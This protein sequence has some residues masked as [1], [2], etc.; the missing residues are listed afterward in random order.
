MRRNRSS[1]RRTCGGSVRHLLGDKGSAVRRS[2]VEV[3]KECDASE[4]APHMGWLV[5]MLGDKDPF[6]HQSVLVVLK[7]CDASERAQ[8]M[9]QLGKVLIGRQRSFRAPVGGGDAEG[10]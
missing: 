3:L 5:E 9:G 2:V 6:V 4:R 10:M 8:R 7:A 1:E